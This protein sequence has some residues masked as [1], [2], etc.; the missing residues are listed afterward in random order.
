MVSNLND[1][2]FGGVIWGQQAP[3]AVWEG[4][5]HGDWAA[6]AAVDL[7]DAVE[8]RATQLPGDTSPKKMGS[9]VEALGKGEQFA[10]VNVARDVEGAHWIVDGHHRS[11]AMRAAG[12]PVRA[13]VLDVSDYDDLYS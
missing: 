1:R 5:E 13:K 4:N 10:P 7:D 3:A 2:Q 8:L 12:M 11:A 6:A 9:I